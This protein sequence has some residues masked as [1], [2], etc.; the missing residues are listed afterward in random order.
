[1]FSPYYKWARRR[2]P[3]DPLD[4]A[5]I[6]VAL[7]G[8]TGH[9]W[10][11]T[12][13]GQHAVTQSTG[14]FAVG[15]SRLVWDGRSLA[16]SLDEVTFPLPGRLQ[17]SIRLTPEALNAEAFALD[18]CGRHWWRPIAPVARVEVTLERPAASWQGSAY[19]DSNWGAEPIEDGFRQWSW[20]RAALGPE[21]V[22]LYDARRRDGTALGLTLGF[23]AT[24]KARHLPQPPPALLPKAP[25]WRMARPT[26]ADAP[27]AVRVVSTFE[28]T[29]FYARSLLETR[30]FGKTAA[31]VHESLSLDR[32]AMPVVQAM[33]PFRM[34]RR[35]G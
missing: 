30:L 32:F 10:A 17:G 13:R 21:S 1:V 27:D 19:L 29:P 23:D 5:A 11:M 33:L 24:G 25:V 20:S 8:A 15:P 26:R 3:A 31:A 4:H 6:N 34:P 28:D 9:R 35:G 12:E 7:Y 16:V 22:V 18:G 2:G 14:S